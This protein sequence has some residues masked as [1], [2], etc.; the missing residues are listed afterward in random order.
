MLAR[1]PRKCPRC[2]TRD[3][4]QFV[5]HALE[6]RSDVWLVEDVDPEVE[7]RTHLPTRRRVLSAVRGG[8]RAGESRPI[9]AHPARRPEE[10][11]GNAAGA[12]R[13]C[14][15][16]PVTSITT[17][18]RSSSNGRLSTPRPDHWVRCCS[19]ASANGSARRWRP[20]FM[21]PYLRRA[22]VRAQ[23]TRH[24]E[25][26]RRLSA[27]HRSGSEILDRIR[28][29]RF[30]WSRSPFGTSLCQHGARFE[31]GLYNM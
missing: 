31:R 23:G 28:C 19:S 10:P 13:Q 3:E 15:D 16:Q 25:Q 17:S 11:W 5:C 9:T 30:A 22:A 14:F 26:S 1:P 21:K 29:W 27:G 20:S 12:G 7:E 8:G 18:V 6:S 2:H 4:R 24:E